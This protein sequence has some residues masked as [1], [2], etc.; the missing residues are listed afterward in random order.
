MDTLEKAELTALIRHIGR[1]LK[2]GIPLFNIEVPDTAGRKTR[3]RRSRRRRAQSIAKCY[4][5]HANAIR[6]H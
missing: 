2:S 6:E 1:F 4:A 5:F 3:K